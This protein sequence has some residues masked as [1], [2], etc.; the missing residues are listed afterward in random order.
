MWTRLSNYLK[1]IHSFL[2]PD[3]YV[4]T[5]ANTW[6]TADRLAG[7]GVLIMGDFN[8]CLSKLT[9]WASINSLDTLDDKLRVPKPDGIPFSSYNGTSTTHSSL[10]DNIFFQTHPHFELTSIG[11]TMHPLFSE[12]TDLNPMTRN[13][14]CSPQTLLQRANHQSS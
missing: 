12:V 9:P 10:I 7:R 14:H 8:K 4:M 11:G 13:P 2:K 6:A 5:A 1:S 3:E